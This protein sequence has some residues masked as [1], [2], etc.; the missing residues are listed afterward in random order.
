MYR[1]VYLVYE[2]YLQIFHSAC[3]KSQKFYRLYPKLTFGVG[4]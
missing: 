2:G 4:W 1:L 3:G